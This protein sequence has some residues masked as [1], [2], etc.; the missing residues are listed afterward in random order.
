MRRFCRNSRTVILA[1]IVMCFVFLGVPDKD[2]TAQGSTY[3]T[4]NAKGTPVWSKASSTSTKIRTLQ[5]GVNVSIVSTLINDAGN[6]WGMT[7]NKTWIFMGNLKASNASAGKTG[8][9]L[10]KKDDVPLRQVA[11][12]SGSISA[13]MK[14]GEQIEIKETYFNDVGNAWGTGIYKGK[15]YVV[16]LENLEISNDCGCE[17][18]EILKT[19]YKLPFVTRLDDI[20]VW[21]SP[22]K[23]STKVRS[24][25]KKGTTV[26]VI[27]RVR[28]YYDNLWMQLDD[29]KFI[30]V[31]NLAFSLDE[32]LMTAAQQV[33][34]ISD[35]APF[36]FYN[37]VKPGGIWD[38]K[39]DNL[40]GANTNE[41]Y[42]KVKGKIVEER[43]TGE[44]IGNIFYGFIGRTAGFSEDIL[45]KASGGVNI[46][47]EYKNSKL[48][49][50]DLKKCFGSYCDN[51]E[52]ISYV[53]R[54]IKLFD[55]GQW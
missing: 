1:I 17:F 52:D 55:V 18:Y 31:D 24:I 38:F 8:N 42:I 45:L 14:S 36:E 16:F 7:I 41:Y 40:L 30:F 48:T 35:Y 13:R 5:K 53:L 21:S 44:E 10:A 20:P 50:D 26:Y 9:Y 25:S 15:T 28:N 32:Q 34:A 23:D 3:I 4:I 49:M 47:K 27:G 22:T 29:G 6:E 46:Y 39:Q 51:P 37:N 2:A 43:L 54:G 11:S 19:S 12:S 33:L